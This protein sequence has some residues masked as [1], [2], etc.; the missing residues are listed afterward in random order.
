MNYPV[1]ITSKSATEG[2]WIYQDEAP[3]SVGYFT[4]QCGQHALEGRILFNQ[5]MEWPAVLAIH[6]A[7]SDFTK[8]NALL[9]PLQK[10]GASTMSFHM[11]GHSLASKVAINATS[12]KNNLAEATHFFEKLDGRPCTVIGHSLGGALACKLVAAYPDRIANLVLFCPAIYGESAYRYPFGASFK[13][14]ISIPYGFL[15]SDSFQALYEFKGTVILVIGQYDGLCSFAHGKNKGISAGLVHVDGVERYSAIPKQVI[16]KIKA[17]VPEQQLQQITLPGC[18]HAISTW[19]RNNP[20][21]AKKIA[22][23]IA[24]QL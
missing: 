7:R 20:A 22:A 15:D 13:D 8:M 5:K 2:D 17:S 19:L 18:D 3:G 4:E 23:S 11:S 6:G 10:Q 24:A 16:D 9:F 14:A 21:Q 1:S 12:L